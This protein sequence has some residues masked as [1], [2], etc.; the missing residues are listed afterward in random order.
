M[1]NPRESWRGVSCARTVARFPAGAA[2]LFRL[3]KLVVPAAALISL[4]ACASFDKRANSPLPVEA[5]NAPSGRIESVR[6]YESGD[7]LFVTGF[8]R[9][10]SSYTVNYPVHAD[11]QLI[12][13]NGKVLTEKQDYIETVSSLRRLQ[14]QSGSYSFRTS[15]PLDQARQAV[16]IRVTYHATAHPEGS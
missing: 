4:S 2:T 14:S 7:T 10:K 1:A 9:R 11:I 13:K 16:A 15:F 5:V 12:G 6:A 8:M 3:A